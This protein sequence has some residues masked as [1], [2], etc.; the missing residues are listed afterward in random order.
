[1]RVPGQQPQ[2][3]HPYVLTANSPSP[4]QLVVATLSGETN[5]H[6]GKYVVVNEPGTTRTPR[7]LTREV[8][9][10]DADTSTLTLYGNLPYTPQAG[11]GIELWDSRY[12]PFAIESYINQAIENANQRTYQT[13]SVDT[14][15]VGPLGREFVVPRGMQYV[16]AVQIQRSVEYAEIAGEFSAWPASTQADYYTLGIHV[17][18]LPAATDIALDVPESLE[19]G[20]WTHVAALVYNHD[21]ASAL[22]I[23][24]PGAAGFEF[25]RVLVDVQGRGW[26]YAVAPLE[27][28]GAIDRLVLNVG[29]LPNS[30]DP[31]PLSVWRVRVVNEDSAQWQDVEFTLPQGTGQVNLPYAY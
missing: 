4:D 8:R 12:P 2:A 31:F 25:G 27:G 19:R 17:R 3:M 1:L 10:F 21:S 26:H 20:R 30:N 5:S 11:T 15:L 24:I 7:D 28:S 23:E 29:N 9:T 18:Q 6:S 14:I 22:A 16:S 13:S